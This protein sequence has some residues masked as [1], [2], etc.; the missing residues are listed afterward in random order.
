[1]SWQYMHQGIVDTDADCTNVESSYCQASG[2]GQELHEYLKTVC[3]DLHVTKG[4]FDE[5]SS[6][7]EQKVGPA[8]RL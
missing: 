6:Y 3:G 4:D 5:D 7:P 1:M 2:C 8:G